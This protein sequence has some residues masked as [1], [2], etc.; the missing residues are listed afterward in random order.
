MADPWFIPASKE[1]KRAHRARVDAVMRRNPGMKR[2]EAAR[3]LSNTRVTAEAKRSARETQIHSKFQKAVSI[4]K[5]LRQGQWAKGPRFNGGNLVV[6][7]TGNGS[8]EIAYPSQEKRGSIA[9]RHYAS[10]PNNSGFGHVHDTD[11]RMDRDHSNYKHY[12]KRVF[13]GGGGGK[14]RSGRSGG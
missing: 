13:G 3:V 9:F 5:G 10:R 11:W 12:N 2:L 6:H 4:G 14:G 1:Y 8:F 7:G